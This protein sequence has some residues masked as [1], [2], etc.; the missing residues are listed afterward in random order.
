MGDVHDIIQRHTIAQLRAF[1]AVLLVAVL[2][3]TAIARSGAAEPDDL[4]A[5]VDALLANAEKPDD[6]GLTAIVV[7]DGK[8]LYRKAFGLANLELRT[9]MRPE[10]VFEIGSIT[11]QFTSTAIMTLVDEGKLAVDDDI[12]K[13]LPDFPDKGAKITIENLLTHTSGIPSY[14]SDDKWPALWRKDLTP[15]E[16]IDLTKDKPL[17]FPPGTKWSY[18]NTGYVMLGAVVEKISGMAY[19]DFVKSRIFE[20][21]GM[22]H[23]YYGS[24]TAVIP[25]RASGYTRGDNGEWQI[26][27]Y[28]SMTQPYAAGSLMSSVD[29]LAVW[30]AAVGDGKLLSK[31][32]WERV[33]TPY[34]LSDGTSTNYGYGWFIDSYDGHPIVRHGGGIFGFVSEAARAPKD[35]VFVALLTNSDRPPINMG[36]VATR[37][38]ALAMGDPYREPTPIAVDSKTLDA[39]AGVYKIDEATER[40]VRREGDH[41]SIQRTARPRTEIFPSQPERVLHKRFVSA[42]QVRPR[43]ERQRHRNGLDV[44][45]RDGSV[46][47]RGANRQASPRRSRRGEGFARRAR[48]LCRQVSDRAVVRH[49]DDARGRAPDGHADGS[50]EG[51]ALP[52][53]RDGVLPQGH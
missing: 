30:S 15:Q 50:A 53:E 9:P 3:S 48:P 44:H 26:A 27:P 8:V 25:N 12:R 46:R 17:E 39:Y 28:L 34:A 4:T 18:D 29:D 16:I 13:I 5:E 6:P 52:E 22:K 36:F 41:L 19:A 45:Q 37:I 7:K 11:K 42:L 1:A 33:F 21:L 35:R 23:S 49:H 20:P 10:M 14:T 32:S 43:P 47:V 2:S 40:I 51:R 38:A 24:N 31:A